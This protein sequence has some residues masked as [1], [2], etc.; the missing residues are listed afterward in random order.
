MRLSELQ[1]QLNKMS[2]A[3]SAGVR[4]QVY[5]VGT[6]LVQ[7]WTRATANGRRVTET[8]NDCATRH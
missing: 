5:D 3:K 2:E 8:A 4:T 7:I 1:L 6:F